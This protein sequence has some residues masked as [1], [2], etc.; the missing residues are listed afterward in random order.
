[1]NL[2][3]KFNDSYKASNGAD[4]AL[5]MYAASNYGSNGFC[6]HRMAEL[7]AHANDASPAPVQ[8]VRGL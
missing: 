2:A 7:Q 8:K 5:G 3:V 4:L 1:M 6:F